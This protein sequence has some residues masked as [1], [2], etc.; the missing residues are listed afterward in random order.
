MTIKFSII[1]PT[2]NRRNVLSR[3]LPTVLAQD[4]PPNE[5]EVI[6][7]VDGS[8]D[9]TTEM[10]QGLQPR[11]GFRVLDQP[12][13]GQAAARNLGLKAAHGEFV[14]N[15]DDDIVCE[16]SLLREHLRE[17]SLADNLVVFGPVLLH[18]ESPPGLAADYWREGFDRFLERLKS[19][20]DQTSDFWIAA[21]GPTTPN[22]SI[23]RKLL[24]TCRGFD[25]TMQYSREDTE[26][27]IRLWKAGARFRFHPDV[28]VQQ[29]YVKS[30]RDL[31][32]MDIRRSTRS[33]V[34]LSRKH[35]EYRAFTG[36][37]RLGSGGWPKRILRRAAATFPFSLQPIFQT[38]FLVLN[39][40]RWIP[41]LRRAGLYLLGCRCEIETFREGSRITGSWKALHAEFGMR[42]P[43]LS[44]HHV[45][46][47]QPGTYP[48]LTVSPEQFERHVRWLH[49]RGYHGILSSDWLRWSQEG[50]ALPGKPVL[51]TFDDSY[52]DIAEYALP[53]LRRY[54]FGATVFVVT[55]QLGG[56][57]TWDE[58]RG[59]KT[60]RLMT[61]EQICLWA[62]QGIEFGAH[63]KT[64]PDLTAMAAAAVAEE[65]R[66]SRDELAALLGCRVASF[67]YPYGRY[68]KV[69]CD[70]AN[71]AF[72]LAFTVDEGLNDLN[73]ELFRLKRTL[74]DPRDSVLALE[75][76][77]RWGRYPF[78]S[79]RA[80]I[81]RLRARLNRAVRR[82]FG[83]ERPSPS[84][85]DQRVQTE[86]RCP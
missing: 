15:L 39:S 35:P 31:A 6:V 52:A 3:T 72:E 62:A 64:H 69:I 10:L 26:L 43:V 78:E 86:A 9:G 80:Q 70:I 68:N 5:Y 7:V 30:P 67:A 56:T 46:P 17:Q 32:Q 41:A 47:P 55:G 83:Q 79:R 23:P 77:L 54:G 25:E 53:L 36:F 59:S 81:L 16:P 71:K 57:N 40:L 50:T 66:G 21:S 11:C 13:R 76:R 65:V 24:V 18:P 29:I 74:V 85:G 14:I 33:M 1:I 4:F 38:L 48:H 51:L 73:T 60:H 2:Y 44:Y 37:S 75:C 49:K 84:C 63:S 8:S 27:G 19:E 58:A 12:N 34:L 20:H 45:G 61:A 22:C 42:L 28:V 82:L